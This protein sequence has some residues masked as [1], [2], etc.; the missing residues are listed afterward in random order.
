MTKAMS[1][2]GVDG[3]RKLATPIADL[4]APM[5]YQGIYEFS[6]EAETPAPAMTRSKF[7]DELDDAAIERIVARVSGPDGPTVKITQLRVLGG[8]MG[9]VPADATAFAH[10]GAQMMFSVYTIFADS[11]RIEQDKR[12]T[13]AYFAGM[14]PAATGVYVNFLDTEGDARVRQAYPEATYRRLAEVKAL[15]ER[16][17]LLN[18]NHNIRPG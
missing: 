15:W 10:R 2:P 14:A 6:A 1:R 4:V 16:A 3:F 18:R 5:P 7:A 13:E 8:A 9:R 11:D 12:W 17:N